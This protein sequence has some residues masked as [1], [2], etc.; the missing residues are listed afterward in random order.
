MDTNESSIETTETITEKEYKCEQCGKACKNQGGLN[1]HMRSHQPKEKIE[2]KVARKRVP[3]GAPVL[4]M[5]APPIKGYVQRWINDDHGR[6]PQSIRGGYNFVNNRDGK[7]FVGDDAESG[8]TDTGSRVSMVVDR[9]TGQKAYLMAIKEEW[10]SD[11]QK[12]KQE[13]CD[14]VDNAIKF[15]KL[16]ESDGDGRYV[17]KDGIKTSNGYVP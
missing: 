11:D 16:E 17:P 8:N 6:L 3:L 15:G 14:Q 10:Y 9:K 2:K 7:T 1:L 4:K 12:L 13:K 5:T